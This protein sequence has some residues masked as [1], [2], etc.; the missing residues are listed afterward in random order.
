MRDER[1][2]RF[3]PAH[4]AH[5]VNIQCF[6]IVIFEPETAFKRY[7]TFSTFNS[8]DWYVNIV[9]TFERILRDDPMCPHCSHNLQ[10][11]SQSLTFMRFESEQTVRESASLQLW[12]KF[13]N[14]TVLGSQGHHIEAL[15]G[16]SLKFWSGSS[17]QFNWN[18]DISLCSTQLRAQSGRET[19]QGHFELGVL[20]SALK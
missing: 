18:S 16:S 11:E 4:V 9:W 10:M 15:R 17:T 2:Y 5:F 8:K 6:N 14:L 13:E 20:Y 1:R 19:F 3:A 12:I 7:S